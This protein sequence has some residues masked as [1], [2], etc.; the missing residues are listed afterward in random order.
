MQHTT[1]HSIKTGRCLSND[2]L[3]Q[4]SRNTSRHGIFRLHLSQT[5]PTHIVLLLPFA[6][7]SLNKF[8][9][10]L[11]QI[12]SGVAIGRPDYTTKKK[13]HTIDTQQYI[14]LCTRLAESAEIG[15]ELV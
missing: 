8:Q 10:L 1:T 13:I 6:G 5:L 12:K 2:I 3:L 9:Q 7:Q 4:S 14:T 11:E 15:S